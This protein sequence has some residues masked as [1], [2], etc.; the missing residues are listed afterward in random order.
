VASSL[1]VMWHR[2]LSLALVG[3][4]ALMLAQ[5]ADTPPP[6]R[7]WFGPAPGSLDMIRL[8]EADNEWPAARERMSVF[9]FYQQQVL[10]GFSASAFGPNTYEAFR[11]V[12]AFR[13]LSREWHKQV[14]VEVGAVKDFYCTADGSGMAAAIGNTR[15][16]IA[17]VEAAGGRIDYLAMD[18]PFLSGR[19]SRCGG[20][21]P[22][23]TAQRL[24]LYVTSVN[25]TSPD[26]EI[27]LI[28]PYPFFSVT[29]L[30]GFVRMLKARGVAPAFFHVDID[31][32]AVRPAT[33][34]SDD[35]QRL[36]FACLAE[37]VPFG[38]II[39]GTN[40]NADALYV[41]DA[42]RLVRVVEGSL[43]AESM[44][45]DL[46]FQSWAESST[47]LMITP[48]N[49]PQNRPD[50]HTYFLNQATTMLQK[51]LRDSFRPGWQWHR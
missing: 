6:S 23:P 41:A 37:D 42:W 30:I 25:Q 18:E 46:I 5:A 51:S 33:R 20:P 36:S 45:R 9:K 15:T 3:I 19:A 48:S 1:T 47:G 12:D 24:Q 49:L 28:E 31:L 43:D 38:V 50:T 13:R 8:F 27:G 21:D 26:T 32:N 17:A 44:P 4:P 22:Q 10:P 2:V 16:A 29:E 11:R 40:G 34:V 35:M 7:I 14:A 39:M